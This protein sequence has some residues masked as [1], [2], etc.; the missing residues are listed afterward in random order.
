MKSNF[1]D[2]SLLYRTELVEH[3]LPFWLQHGL[4]R[5]HGGIYT[6]VDREGVLMDGT[7]SV[8]FQGRAAYSFA[9][10]YNNIE[11]RPEWLEACEVILPFLEEKCFDPHDGRMYF[12]VKADGTPL[13]KRRYVFSESFAIIA[14]AEYAKASGKMEYA[15]K[16]LAL[17]KQVQIWLSLPG[18]LEPKYLP[19]QPAIGHSISMIMMNVAV[20]LHSVI[21]D[22]ALEAQA[23]AS[24]KLIKEKLYQ[25]QYH[26][27]LEMVTPEGELIDTLNGRVINPGHCIETAWFLMEAARTFEGKEWANEAKD[28]AF[29]VL[30]DAWAWGWDEACGG[31]IINFRDCKGFPPQDYSQD[32]KFWWPQ[33][34]AIIATLYAYLLSGNSKYLEWHQQAHQWAWQHLPDRTHGE[35][36]GYL[37][38]DGSVAQPAKGNLFKGPFHIPRMLV[39]STLLCNELTEQ[40]K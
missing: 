35:W 6:C 24:F 30:D 22:P 19:K 4:D 38:R 33:T 34:E 8:W 9:Y 18:Y 15:Q 12:E 23:E 20:V 16:A 26:C 39:K 31:G 36:Y 7:K 37:H 27:V 1:R 5:E 13:R 2:Y 29:T 3:I 11:Q 25:P 10:A 40:Q 28:F 14:W 17:F 32:M 21:E